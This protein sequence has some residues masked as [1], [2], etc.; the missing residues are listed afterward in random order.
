[1]NLKKEKTQPLR[2]HDCSFR[3]SLA[4]VINCIHLLVTTNLRE[5]IPFRVSLKHIPLSGVGEESFLIILTSF[6]DA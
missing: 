6:I 4:F 2:N 1:M 5:T 3:A